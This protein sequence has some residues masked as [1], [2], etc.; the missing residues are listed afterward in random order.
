[1][2]EAERVQYLKK[3]LEKQ[4]EINRKRE[5]VRERLERVEATKPIWESEIFPNWNNVRNS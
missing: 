2:V 3:K 5:Q 4:K 1:M